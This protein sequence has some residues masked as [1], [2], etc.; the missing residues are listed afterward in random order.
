[1]R[2]ARTRMTMRVTIRMAASRMI[3]MMRSMRGMISA[4]TSAIMVAITAA[5]MHETMNNDAQESAE[6]RRSGL[7]RE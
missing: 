7:R 2:D 6:L 4:P 1:M 5:A 3:R